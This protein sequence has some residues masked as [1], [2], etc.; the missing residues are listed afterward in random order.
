MTDTVV[1]LAGRLVER[2]LASGAS[3]ADAVATLSEEVFVNRRLGKLEDLDRSESLALGL[4]V[5]CGHRQA[6]VAT[7]DPSPDTADELIERAVAMAR[8]AP[9]DHHAGLAEPPL[10]IDHIVDL[11]LDD[12]DEP[13]TDTLKQLAAEAEDAALGVPDIT[14]SE[15][16]SAAWR[17]STGALVT[18]SGFAGVMRRTMSSLYVTVIAGT[19]LDMQSDGEGRSARHLKDLPAPAEIGRKAA[20]RAVRKLAPRKLATARMPLVFEPRTA[21][22]LVGHLAGFI[23]G[24]AIARGTSWLKDFLDCQVFADGITIRED[25]F[26]QRGLASRPFD[27]EGLCPHA[28]KLVD[29]GILVTWLLDCR[30]ARQLAM[31]PTG[32]ATRGAGGPPSVGTTNV[33]LE[34]GE[35]SPEVLMA[36]IDEGLYVTSLSGHGINPVTGD[37]SRGASGQRIRNGTLD[38]AINEITVAGNLK[39]IYATLRPASDLEFRA[40]TN[41][42]SV[43]VDTMTV[44]GSIG[45]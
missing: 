33:W 11:D 31:Q 42:P 41:A 43:R 6:S 44:A 7:T 13:A 15:G 4:R 5:F 3:T 36:D 1:D 20:E 21:R 34:A 16:A 10:L 23:A 25:P 38:H 30:S 40:A 29:N 14:N 32:H 37:Y 35:D 28:G 27:G 2:A 8:V 17:R 22:S 26:V 24:P 12:G 18:S 45:G 9:E 19:G 39:E